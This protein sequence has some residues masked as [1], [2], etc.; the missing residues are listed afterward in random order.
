MWL[1]LCRGQVLLAE[2]GTPYL[3]LETKSH[4]SSFS[5][6]DSSTPLPI[7][8]DTEGLWEKSHFSTG[9]GENAQRMVD[10]LEILEGSREQAIGYSMN[11]QVRAQTRPFNEARSCPNA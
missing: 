10:G 5:L 7:A 9:K 6:A 1:P 3:F 8:W 11:V 2:S 4:S